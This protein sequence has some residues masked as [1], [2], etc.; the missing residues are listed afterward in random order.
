MTLMQLGSMRH[1]KDPL[2][3]AVL[4]FIREIQIAGHRVL[5]HP[6][7]V[8]LEIIRHAVGNDLAVRAP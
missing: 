5:L 8:W 2:V 1:D 7:E 4:A 3:E 6:V